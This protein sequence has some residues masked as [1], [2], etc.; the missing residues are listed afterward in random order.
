MQSPLDNMEKSSAEA[1]QLS[2]I[3]EEDPASPLIQSIESPEPYLTTPKDSG[4]V[5]TKSRRATPQ[6]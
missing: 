5:E 2:A 1:S 6:V 4:S 3:I